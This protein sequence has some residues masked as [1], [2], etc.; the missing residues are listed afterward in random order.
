MEKIIKRASGATGAMSSSRVRVLGINRDRVRE[1]ASLVKS[2]SGRIECFERADPQF[3]AIERLVARH[4]CGMAALLVVANAII[5]Y[6][7]NVRGEVYWAA[8]SDWFTS[9]GFADPY[10]EH[11]RFLESTRLNTAR[12]ADK[13]KRLLRFYKSDLAG[14]ILEKPFEY[15]LDLGRLAKAVATVLSTTPSSKTVAF[16]GK[17]MRYVCLACGASTGGDVEIPLDRRNALLL[18]SSCIV[19]GC[20]A[21][22][23]ECA[24]LLMTRHRE[25]GL[26]AMRMLCEESGVECVRLDALTWSIAGVLGEGFQSLLERFGQCVSDGMESVFARLYSELSKCYS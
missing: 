11:A 7:L 8:F 2:V 12:L 22:A 4:G 14:R 24:Q 26:E 18:V 20:R 15:C 10:R 13:E 9:R 21:S 6:Q 3:K 23:R 19:G 1:I 17:M 5:S 16:A 25:L